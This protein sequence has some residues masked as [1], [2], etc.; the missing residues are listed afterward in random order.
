MRTSIYKEVEIFRTGALL[1]TRV[2]YYIHAE[3]SSGFFRKLAS[4]PLERG[5]EQK[6]QARVE[7]FVKLASGEGDAISLSCMS[8][9]DRRKNSHGF[10]GQDVD[11]QS[12]SE[13]VVCIDETTDQILSKLLPSLRT[14]I[15][16]PNYREP[17]LL[18]SQTFGAV[19][20]SEVRRSYNTWG[21]D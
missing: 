11:V 16:H 3:T 7:C 19:A 5:K 2:F 12:P 6:S 20:R 8:P 21:K 4:R 13:N 14:T 17:P 1:N 10:E 18:S 15:F 9:L